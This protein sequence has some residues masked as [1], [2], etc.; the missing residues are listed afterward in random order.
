M[1]VS[2]APRQLALALDHVESHAREDFIRGASNLAAFNLIERW[3]DWP[4]RAA[5]I[6][7][8]QGAGKSHLA[9]IWA[10]RSGARTISASAL[11]GADLPS[12][13]ATGALVVEEL[14]ADVYDE[15]ALFHLL[16]MAR[17][18][19]AWILITARSAP[20]GWATGLRDLNSRLRSMV[21]VTLDPPDE[22]LLRALLIKLAADRQV[23]LD[24]GVI[25]YLIVRIERTFLGVH[26]AIERID[27]E[28]LQRKRPVTRALAADLFR[29]AAI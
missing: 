29:D 5:V 20:G 11:G 7:G 18:D 27:R 25:N 15:R 24:D 14:A 1:T 26:A 12:T 17:E 28:A 22:R 23:E 3:P 9:S 2:A 16:N 4:S 21:T 19:N 8:P 10:E 13:L 6:V